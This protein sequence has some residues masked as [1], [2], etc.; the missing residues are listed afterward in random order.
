M[1]DKN[2]KRYL[3][4]LGA[5]S[6]AFGCAVGWGAFIMPGTT[7]LPI[8]GPLGTAIGMAVGAVIML[9]IGMNYHYMMNRHPDAGGIYSYAKHE[10]GYDHGVLS[11]WF[12]I[13]VYIAIIWANATALPL[14]ARNLLGDTFKVGPHYTILEYD[15]YLGEAALV[16]AAM[17]AA[18][19]VCRL[20]KRGAVGV[21]IAM[22]A[23][24][25][26]GVVLGLVFM[27]GRHGTDVFRLKPLLVPGKAP[28]MSILNIVVL[29]PWAFAGFESISQSTEEFAF[30]P[31]KALAIMVAAVLAGGFIYITLSLL[32]AAA[33]PEGYQDWFA[34]INDLENLKGI[35]GLP[36][37]H[38]AIV[39]LGK[40]G[41]AVLAATIIAGIVTGLI[42]NM[43]A[44]SRLIYSMAKDELLPPWFSRLNRHGIPEDAIVF[45]M[46][47]SLPIPF[48]GR[49]AI[50]WIVDVNT[51]GATIAYLYTSSVALKVA[52]EEKN[53]VMVTTGVLGTVIS[54]MFFLYFML[55]NFWT[56]GGMSTG[57]YMLL[58]TWSILGFVYFRYIFQNDKNRR[59]GRSTIVWVTMLFLIFFASMLWLREATHETT[60][61]VMG[62]L[63]NYHVEELAE[64]G[65]SQ[66]TE[67][68][69][70]SAYY[71]Q[72]QLKWVNSELTNN[73]LVQMALLLLA[74]FIMFNIY[75]SMMQREK[76]MEVAKIHAEEG[77]K[78]KSTFLSNMSHDIRTPMNAIVGYVGLLKK[79]PGMSPKAVEY[80]GKIESSSHHLLTLINDILDM[81]RIESGKMELDEK[82]TN[83]VRLLDEVHDLF[84]TQMEMKQINYVVEA[85]QVTHKMVFCD[86][87]RLSRV[88]M[89][90][91]SNAY[92]FTPEGGTV[93][94]TLRQLNAVDGNGSYE[95]K[96]KDSGLGMSPEFAAKVFEAY[97]RERTVSKIQGTG[98]G[99][100]ITKNIVD[101]MGGTIDVKTEQ[102]KGTE[103]TIHVEFALSDEPDKSQET[104]ES[105]KKKAIDFS[106]VRLLL[107]E[108]N[109]I[110]RE[111]ASLMLEDAGF[112]LEVAENG[113]IAVE[114]V[115]SSEPGY[116]Q[117]VL[118][119]VQ[120]PVMNGYEATKAIRG[121]SDRKL[122]SIPIIAMTAN[123]FAEDVQAAKDAGMDGHIAKPVSMDKM[124]ETLGDVL[125]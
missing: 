70:D 91:V 49:T 13:L 114:K 85:E 100:A 2:L 3:S 35:E 112:M 111:I 14:V 103:F 121:L 72:K 77:S 34:Y 122:A 117:L 109:E 81:S 71:L 9:V 63:N 95:L 87:N 67:S 84:A 44:A 26:G 42:G 50:G 65:V 25:L 43:V 5:W 19:L 90:L 64:H 115:A 88:L 107:V 21:Q 4:P 66:D 6:L 27:L 7:F 23:L 61:I 93:T 32:A 110:N 1:D 39:Y 48:L 116:Y 89:N 24:L 33:T 54:L 80:L 106:K 18:G 38:S 30:S 62:R 125:S 59:V 118:M 15:V 83:I 124:M 45:I 120:M 79:E 123:A 37:F 78:A 86:S 75:K 31:R 56:V 58:I 20:S 53:T 68:K 92:K 8:A 99:M 96:V 16:L 104:Q 98:L 82:S 36:V 69:M 105:I 10:L 97:E 57:S 74:L 52:C 113:K 101:L 28:L 73:S 11:A 22:A 41:V 40:P 94:V 55:P 51:I 47:L 17:L 46:L 29:A 76:N 119:D 102:G 60:G 108:D 12:L